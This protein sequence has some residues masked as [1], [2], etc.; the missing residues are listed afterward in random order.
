MSAKGFAQGCNQQ[1]D[2][3]GDALPIEVTEQT[4]LD[5]RPRDQRSRSQC[6]FFGF[7]HEPFKNGKLLSS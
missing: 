2:E 1:F 7:L 4:P 6:S 5:F 3:P